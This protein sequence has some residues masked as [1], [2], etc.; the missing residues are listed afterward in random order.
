MNFFRSL[1]AQWGERYRKMS[2]QMVLSLSFTTVAAAGILLMG[3][4]LIWRF[5]ASCPEFRGREAELPFKY[6]AEIVWVG[7]PR[8][9]RNAIS[10]FNGNKF[11]LALF[12]GERTAGGREQPADAGS[13]Q[14]ESGQ[15]PAA[16]DADC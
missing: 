14:P 1:A 12:S 2:I 15:L 16:D 5:S 8:L 9:L 13:G 7:V 3:I 11:D 10:L 6:I 4:S